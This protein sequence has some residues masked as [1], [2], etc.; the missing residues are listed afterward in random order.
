VM[1]TKS[2]Y[3]LYIVYKNVKVTWIQYISNAPF[4]H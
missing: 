2:I 4:P 1:E 3:I